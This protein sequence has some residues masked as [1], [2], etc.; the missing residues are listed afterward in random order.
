M[1][2]WF[3]EPQKSQRAINRTS[4][5]QPAAATTGRSLKP[6]FDGFVSRVEYDVSPFIGFTGKPI[7]FPQRRLPA[8]LARADLQPSSRRPPAPSIQPS[9]LTLSALGFLSA[10]TALLA[11]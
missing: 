10:A 11:K 3:A 9:W 4:A 8:N 2:P 6:V 5:L 1:E 7:V